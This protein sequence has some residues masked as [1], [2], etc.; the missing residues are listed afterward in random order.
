M[1]RIKLTLKPR[2][3]D[4]PLDPALLDEV[5]AAAE[6]AIP[7][8]APATEYA[9][10]EERLIPDEQAETRLHEH[11]GTLLDDHDALLRSRAEKAGHAVDVHRELE[12]IAEQVR[13]DA[14]SL[15]QERQKK[16]F[17]DTV[18]GVVDVTRAV[19]VEGAKELFRAFVRGDL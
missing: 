11:V 6:A 4:Q 5:L 2:P 17:Q 10:D 13:A 8:V 9:D 1:K 19:L 15:A 14:P 7:P 3:T 12:E 18:A 16:K